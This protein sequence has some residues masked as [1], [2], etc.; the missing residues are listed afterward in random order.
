MYW[1]VCGFALSFGC[2][3]YYLSWTVMIFGRGLFIKWSISKHDM[4]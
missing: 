3:M 2:S 4:F 1:R